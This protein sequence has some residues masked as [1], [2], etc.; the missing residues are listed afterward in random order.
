MSLWESLGLTATCG[1]SY[2]SGLANLLWCGGRGA[3]VKGPGVYKQYLDPAFQ[4]PNGI[5]GGGGGGGG[6]ASIAVRSWPD[7]GYRVL[8][9]QGKIRNERIEK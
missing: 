9:A 7:I 6:T 2:G 3:A 1:N 5:C 8:F 4:S